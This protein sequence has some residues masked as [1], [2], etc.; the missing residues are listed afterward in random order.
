LTTYPPTRGLR[1]WGLEGVRLSTLPLF[2]LVLVFVFVFIVIVI[3]PLSI[4]YSIRHGLVPSLRPLPHALPAG[5][6]HGR[7]EASAADETRRGSGP[8]NVM[9][10]T[11]ARGAVVGLPLASIM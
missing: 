6:R 1:A 3:V 9:P 4:Q 7:F 5:A 8:R 10:G 11:P 2:V